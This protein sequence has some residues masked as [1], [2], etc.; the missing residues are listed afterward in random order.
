MG[1]V[2]VTRQARAMTEAELHTWFGYE[3]QDMARE[4]GTDAYCGNWN[5]NAGLE[6]LKRPPQEAL[7]A[8]AASELL[9]KK[10]YKRGPV[11]AVR[12][13]NF[14]LA[15]P[16]TAADKDL[17]QR[18]ADATKAIGLFD[19]NILERGQKAKSK[20][21]KCGKCES[22]I[23][24]HAMHKPKQAEYLKMLESGGGGDHGSGLYRICGQVYLTLSRG[25]TSC[26][27]CDHELLKTETDRKAEKALAAKVQ[28]L[29]AKKATAAQ[30]YA[31]AQKGKVSPYWLVSGECG[32]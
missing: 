5:S 13:G 11:L 16:S 17:V 10:V 24:V 25:L 9:E 19:W 14:N 28:D 27:V 6:V 1:A 7:T 26:P 18:L 20:T 29:T 23:N 21:K 4:G 2:T 12:V 31:D 15:F 22:S 8:E 30:K 32:C 3:C